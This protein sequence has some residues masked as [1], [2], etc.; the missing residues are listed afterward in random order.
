[1]ATIQRFEQIEGW[2]EARQL[3]R[4]VY[5][6]T[7][8]GA[9]AKDFALRDQIR[10]A[11]VSIMSNIAEGFERDGTGEFLQFLSTAKGSAGEVKAQIYVARD[12]GYLNEDETNALLQRAATLGKLIAG[13]MNYLR[14]S[15]VRGL[16]YRDD[17][18]HA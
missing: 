7:A 18:P 6:V 15:D 17:S 8:Q 5:R 9:F 11:S 13:F 3:T 12:Q 1:M 16:K 4:D 10:P 2:Q 14:R